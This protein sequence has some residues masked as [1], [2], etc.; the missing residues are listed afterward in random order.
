MHIE[1][2]AIWS[3]DIE[4][5]RAFYETYFGA[6]AG[7]KYTNPRRGF[8]SYFL[9]FDGGCRLEIM[10]MPGIAVEETIE[11]RAGLAHFAVS[12]GSEEAV[13]ALTRRLEQ[14]GCRVSGGPRRTGD[15]YYESVVLDPDGNRVEITV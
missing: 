4:Q 14:D 8:Q 9:A 11:P 13:D 15:G 12:A 2:L 3:E 1:H 7:Q 5:L 6:T 10:Q